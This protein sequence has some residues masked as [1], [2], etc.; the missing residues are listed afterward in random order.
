MIGATITFVGMPAAVS[1]RIARS[2]ASGE[3]VRGSIVRAST[4]SS[5]VIESDT[6]IALCAA[7]CL[8]RSISRVTSAFFVMIPIG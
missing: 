4:G 1:S 8:N 2:R 6:R 3:L 5:V 7:S